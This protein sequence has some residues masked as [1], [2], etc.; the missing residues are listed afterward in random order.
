MLCAVLAAALF[1]MA[2]AVLVQA[3]AVLAL[4]ALSA[5][6]LLPHPLKWYAGQGG[7]AVGVFFDSL[8][9]S[10]GRSPE[11]EKKVSAHDDAGSR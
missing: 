7:E 8:L 6:V 5:V 3:L 1:C 11:Q 9:T 2:L 4:A 10:L